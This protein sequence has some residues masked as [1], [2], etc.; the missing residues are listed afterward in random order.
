MKQLVSMLLSIVAVFFLSGCGDSNSAF[1]I[2]PSELEVNGPGGAFVGA[3]EFSPAMIEDQPFYTFDEKNS[4]WIR[5]IFDSNDQLFYELLEGSEFGGTYSIED[6]KIVVD[7]NDKNPIIGL[8]VAKATVWEVTGTDNDGKVW[9][10]TWHLELKFTS[11]MLVGKR[12]SSEFEDY[13]LAVKE[14]LLFTA[15]TLEIYDTGGNLKK[16]LPYSF[17][18]GTLVIT[19]DE[20]EFTLSLMFIET[21][22]KLNV[23][24][25]SEIRSRSGISVWTLL[26]G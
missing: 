11:E 24:Y 20:G 13:G 2:E 7:D 6:G 19:D 23:W 4:W 12:F 18:D 3:K 5:V 8:D 25:L 21:D 14:E 16:K 9:Q 17:E 26:N 10:D 22:G 15:T 1:I